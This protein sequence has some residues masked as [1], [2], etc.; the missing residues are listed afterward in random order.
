MASVQAAALVGASPPV[1]PLHTSKGFGLAG[2]PG[3]A[4]GGFAWPIAGADAATPTE[5]PA[6]TQTTARAILP[7]PRIA[8]LTPAATRLPRRSA[9]RRQSDKILRLFKRCEGANRQFR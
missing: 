5:T 3:L 1:R 9:V 6:T 7:K 2:S 8:F 4:C